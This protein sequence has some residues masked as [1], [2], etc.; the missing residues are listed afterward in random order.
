MK[1]RDWIWKYWL[2]DRGGVVLWKI[3]LGEIDC[4]A[5]SDPAEGVAIASLAENILKVGLLQPLLLWKSKSAQDG[6]RYRLIAGRRRLEALRMLGKTHADAIVTDCR[7]EELPLLALSD[8]FLHRETDPFAMADRL[9]MLTENGVGILQLSRLLGTPSSVLESVLS[10]RF[11]DGEQRRFLRL[12]HPSLQD[13]LAYLTIPESVRQVF[14]RRA[15]DEGA[16]LSDLVKDYHR[17]PSSFALQTCKVWTADLRLFANTIRRAVQ[18]M[19]DAG[20][21]CDVC[22]EEREDETVFTI[23]L[24][25]DGVLSHHSQRLDTNKNVSRETFLDVQMH[26][27]PLRSDE[28]DMICK[29]YSESASEED[30]TVNVSRETLPK[31]ATKT[32][33]EIKDKTKKNSKFVL[34]R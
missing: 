4:E 2:G 34:T 32:A 33:K 9:A 20:F 3:P 10:I 24:R 31:N 7:E 14:L 29:V 30:W 13:I 8:N 25:K 16:T 18:T 21:S 22:H 1:I 27:D 23:H 12:C 5:I 19:E 6:T 15:A 11:L 28:V 26:G 17:N